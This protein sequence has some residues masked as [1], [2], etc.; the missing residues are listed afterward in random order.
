MIAQAPILA[1]FLI[2]WMLSANGSKANAL[3]IAFAAC[4]GVD[5]EEG[6]GLCKGVRSE[7]H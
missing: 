1:K 4:A 2:I 5:M 3:F 7:R 6:A